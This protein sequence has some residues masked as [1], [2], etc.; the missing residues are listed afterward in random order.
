MFYYKKGKKKRKIKPNGIRGCFNCLDVFY[1]IFCK[2]ILRN[3]GTE[4]DFDLLMDVGLM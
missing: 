2:S 1:V 4:T 3:K